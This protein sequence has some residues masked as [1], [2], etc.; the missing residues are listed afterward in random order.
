M[1]ILDI[2][3]EIKVNKNIFKS[4]SYAS[5]I[6]SDFKNIPKN[7]FYRSPKVVIITNN[8]YVFWLELLII[9]K[10]WNVTRAVI[11]TKT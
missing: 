2:F 10:L 7:E 6:H 5:H 4:V 9:P 3:P 8:D 1:N 11:V